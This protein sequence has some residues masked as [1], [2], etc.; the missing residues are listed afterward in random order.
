MLR[1]ICVGSFAGSGACCFQNSYR[2]T[3]PKLHLPGSKLCLWT[4]LKLLKLG[5]SCGF[6]GFGSLWLK[7]SPIAFLTASIFCA[8]R[9]PPVVLEAEVALCGSR[10]L[11]GGRNPQP[12]KPQTRKALKLES[13]AAL[14]PHHPPCQ[15]QPPGLVRIW[16][17]SGGWGRRV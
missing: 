12:C 4:L 16:A 6:E 7:T 2:P 10:A 17:I 9:S 8:K 1:G 14:V 11:M 3:S 15:E 13:R 5:A